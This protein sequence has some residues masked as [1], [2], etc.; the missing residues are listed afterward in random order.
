[1]TS[2]RFAAII[3]SKQQPEQSNNYNGKIHSNVT[4]TKKVEYKKEKA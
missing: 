4:I 2:Q 1:M 3:S